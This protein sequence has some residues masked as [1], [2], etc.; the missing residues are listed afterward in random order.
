MLVAEKRTDDPTV[1]LSQPPGDLASCLRRRLRRMRTGNLTAPSTGHSGKP[2][3][4]L[5]RESSEWK[6]QRRSG[7]RW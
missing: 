7:S 4:G 1:T 6:W 5:V 2:V 3:S